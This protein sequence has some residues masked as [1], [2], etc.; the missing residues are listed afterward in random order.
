MKKFIASLLFVPAMANAEFLSGNDLLRDM[1]SKG[2]D[3][4]LAIG[5]VLG[6]ADVYVRN[7]ICLPENIKAGQ[8][9]DV[10][11]RFLEE[12]PA[13][14]HYSADSLILF[15]LEELWPCAKGKGA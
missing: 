14:R 8:L 1:N 10:I 3:Q 7:L 2:L 6:V 4:M 13:I 11:K 15:R 5:Y 9:H 12:N